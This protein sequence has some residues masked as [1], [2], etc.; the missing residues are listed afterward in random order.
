MRADKTISSRLLAMAVVT[1]S[2]LFSALAQ[3]Y[4]VGEEAAARHRT[5]IVDREGKIPLAGATVF[6]CQGKAIGVT[7]PNGRI[8]YSAP[9]DLPLTVRYI[10][11]RELSVPDNR[12]DTI[13]MEIDP[14]ELPEVVAET[15][16]HKVL[17]MLA[18]VR[19]YSTLSSYTDS[20]YLFREKMVDFMIPTQ[21]KGSFKGWTKPRV[22]SSRSYYRFTNAEG[23]DSVS[24]RC[25]QHFSWADW[26]GLIPATS[27][28][29]RLPDDLPGVCDTVAGRYGASEIWHRN[30]DKINI[31]IDIMADTAARRWADG[32]GAFF[33]KHIDFEQF[34][35]KVNYCNVA[36]TEVTPADITGYSFNI[37]SKGRGR[38][39]FMF[40]RPDEPFYVS[41]YAE[42]YLLDREYITVGEA[43]KW[44]R[45]KFNP[46][47]VEIYEPAE[48]PDL[49]PSVMLL[50]D[51]VN[52]IDP[53]AI[54]LATDPDRRLIARGVIKRNFVEQ[55]FMRL[56]NMLFIGQLRGRRKNKKDWENFR[57]E[58]VAHNNSL[59]LP[60]D[61][62]Q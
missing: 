44:E 10:G 39:M 21:S 28:P 11:Y 58:R 31:E 34:L 51:R 46:G 9:E 5:V 27:I 7:A 49:D 3:E 25:G 19:E 20:V 15:R 14:R 37:E 45:R 52:N 1:V 12:V 61:P 16:S 41:T 53:E 13:Y 36:G 50:V 4:Y 2:A 59:P 35:L 6:N 48:A 26:V 62:A 38:G 57:R 47:D 60:S 43:R 17:H 29:D 55:A 33:R 24:D 18:Y 8:P 56:K 22:L 40:N 32:M 30:G 23:L 42:V 54:R